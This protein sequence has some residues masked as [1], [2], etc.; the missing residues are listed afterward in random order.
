MY[1]VKII[2]LFKKHSF[3]VWPTRSIRSFI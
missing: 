2:W 1:A 3:L